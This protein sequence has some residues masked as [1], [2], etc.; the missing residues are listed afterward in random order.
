MR[1]PRPQSGSRSPVWPSARSEQALSHDDEVVP[2]QIGIGDVL[3][4]QHVARV[5]GE[6]RVPVHHCGKRQSIRFARHAGTA[7]FAIEVRNSSV[8]IAD[9]FLL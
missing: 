9:D 4:D 1:L 6:H 3:H 5:K 2:Q 7:D 8:L